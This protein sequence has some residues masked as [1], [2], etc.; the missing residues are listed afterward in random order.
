M[1]NWTNV[2]R[3]IMDARPLSF[4]LI[5]F[6]V[7]FTGFIMMNLVIAV[8]CESLSAMKNKSNEEV[9]VQEVD[10]ADDAVGF[11]EDFYDPPDSS[12]TTARVVAVN[13]PTDSTMA[14]T[15]DDH[16]RS[17]A[18]V[19]DEVKTTQSEIREI[20]QAIMDRLQQT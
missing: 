7:T 9:Q 20:L 2:T 5:N 14:H 15:R 4:V 1:D 16:Q 11:A 17:L 10:A 18:T 13:T 12:K 8:V 6:Y 19:T 3:E